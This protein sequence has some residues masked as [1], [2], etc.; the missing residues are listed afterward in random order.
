[1]ATT[2]RQARN[3][4]FQRGSGV[5]ACRCCGRNTRSTGGDGAGVHLCDECFELAGYENLAQDDEP[6]SEADKAEVRRLVKAIV[7]KGGD[8][9]DT[10][11]FPWF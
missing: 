8:A 4:H 3:S 11:L 9:P 7:E 6:F 10:S 1:M 5:Y 2:L